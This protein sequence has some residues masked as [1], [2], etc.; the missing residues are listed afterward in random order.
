MTLSCGNRGREAIGR[1]PPPLFRALSMEIS[2]LCQI[3]GGP[4]RRA[5]IALSGSMKERDRGGRKPG[6]ER[7]AA[8]GTGACRV[9]CRRPPS[10]PAWRR[11]ASASESARPAR[12]RA[13]PLASA[14]VAAPRKK[15]A[16]A[17]CARARSRAS[18]GV[19]PS[20]EPFGED[21]MLG[22]CARAR[23]ARRSGGSAAWR[24]SEPSWRW[25]SMRAPYGRDKRDARGHRARVCQ[26][27]VTIDTPRS[28]AVQ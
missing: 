9:A 14:R 24:A 22:N 12:P 5:A 23:V 25:R 1:R 4:A 15:R 13:R 26:R 16:A 27:P 10:P 17:S 20:V 18:G 2:A 6:G 19:G 21:A 11:A 8:P 28:L 7:R 3:A